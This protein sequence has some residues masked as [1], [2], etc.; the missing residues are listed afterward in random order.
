[1][2][3]VLPKNVN[4]LD[5]LPRAVPAER[6]RKN[7]FAAN[8]TQY[9]PGQTI[10]IEVSDPRS[11]LDTTNSFL[12]FSVENQNGAGGVFSP[13]FGGGQ[14]FIRNFRVQQAGNTIMNI[15][16]YSRLYN[17]IIA[18][19]TGGAQWR[20]STS[21]YENVPS[22]GTSPG[23]ATTNVP[24]TPAETQGGIITGLSCPAGANSLIPDGL[25]ADFCVPLIG[26]LFSQDKLI[27]LPMLNQPIQLIFDINNVAE[28]GVFDFAP[29][30][31]DVLISN[32]RY[33][34][35]LIEVPRDVLGFLSQQQAAHGGSLVIPASSYEFQRSNLEAG[36]TG[37]QILEI[38]SRKKSIK[39]VLFAFMADAS[40]IEAFAGAAGSGMPGGEGAHSVFSQSTSAN[41]CLVS[42]QLRA[43]T[44]VI[45]P[46][47]IQCAG[48]RGP[49]GGAGVNA[50][51]A[52]VAGLPN[53]DNNK[54][55]Q[56]FELSKAFGHLGS[57]MGLGA[58]T[59][60]TYSNP[61]LTFGGGQVRIGTNWVV[62]Q[63]QAGPGADGIGQPQD[64]A[65]DEWK[66]CPF[67]LDL[68]AYQ[69][70][71]LMSGLDTKSLSLQMQLFLEI[72]NTRSV[73][74]TGGGGLA[75][76][77]GQSSAINVDL[78]SY[79]DILYYFNSNGT[80]TFSD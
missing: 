27:P 53:N 37:T 29:T 2:E 62:P 46:T 56:V 70:E 48:G 22:F 19:C 51:V 66:F 59:R 1:M 11:F 69:H 26:G 31:N 30:A 61:E 74:D 47:P 20:S 80:I 43:G 50:G 4:Y 72:A 65:G 76:A 3:S 40:T 52:P 55:E 15:Q 45:P 5:T 28:L 63:G 54:G 67:A 18:P 39:S 13:E 58:L 75:A 77:A 57:T 12:R 44:H 9:R 25:T 8:G 79:H 14:T 35:E 78:Y 42:Y 73:P 16:E 41:P 36:A 23:G 38:P 71:A 49:P 60:L 10:I 17:A 64:V 24:A 68:E 7:F 32:V 21:V 33:C 34:A 6:K